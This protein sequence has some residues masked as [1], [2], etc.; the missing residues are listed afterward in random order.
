M[1]LMCC[2]QPEPFKS[3]NWV[4][5]RLTI[6]RLSPSKRPPQRWWIALKIYYEPT[7]GESFFLSLLTRP[8]EQ[9]FI[10][11]KHLEEEISKIERRR[12]NGITRRGQCSETVNFQAP[13]KALLKLGGRRRKEKTFPTFSFGFARKFLVC[14]DFFFLLL[15]RLRKV[16]EEIGGR[17]EKK[18]AMFEILMD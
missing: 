18:F 15:T 4:D 9:K 10:N 12:D 5:V 2:K 1:D 13:L 3:N 17:R 11:F 14:S 6:F 16:H 7:D 8:K